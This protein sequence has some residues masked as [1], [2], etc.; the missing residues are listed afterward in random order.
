MNKSED[1]NLEENLTQEDT[2]PTEKK[3]QNVTDA[4]KTEASAAIQ[5]E[6]NLTNEQK[7]FSLLAY[8]PMGFIPALVTKSKDEYCKY[9]AK[10]GAALFLVSLAAIMIL[11]IF[12]I[13]LGSFLLKIYLLLYVVISVVAAKKAY[14]GN[15]WPIP[16]IS[17][18]LSQ[19]DIDKLGELSD[20]M[21]DKKDENKPSSEK[22]NK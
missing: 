8:I 15:K 6:S 9:H 2:A 22:D 20:K 18:F 14:D 16:I 5:K 11:G 10:Q 17:V 4:N 13:F 19:I 12:S 1:Q 21:L 3:E 7:I